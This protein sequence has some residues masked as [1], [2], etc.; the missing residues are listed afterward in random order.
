ML[1]SSKSLQNEEPFH[2]YEKTKFFCFI[3]FVGKEF[4]VS[5]C[6]VKPLG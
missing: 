2:F 1:I 4:L 6:M 5:H 3:Q